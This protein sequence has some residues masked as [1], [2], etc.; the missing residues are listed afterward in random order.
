MSDRH[1]HGHLDKVSV[2]SLQDQKGPRTSM[3][4]PI[5]MHRSCSTKS[6]CKQCGTHLCRIGDTDHK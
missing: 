2:R 1:E 4:A 5:Y 3:E 6:T